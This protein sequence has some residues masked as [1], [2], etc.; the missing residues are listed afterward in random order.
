M[1]R[2]VDGHDLRLRQCFLVL[3]DAVTGYDAVFL[4]ADQHRRQLG[5][6]GTAQ[7]PGQAGVEHVGFPADAGALGASIFEQLEL[8]RRHLTTVDVGELVL[9]AGD[10][11]AQIGIDGAGEHVVDLAF[12]R[13]DAHGA[14]QARLL[15]CSG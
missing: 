8:L 2:A 9:L 6:G 14:H 13:L 4:A 7:Q 5:V 12:I 10:T 1:T 3:A 11:G 15:S